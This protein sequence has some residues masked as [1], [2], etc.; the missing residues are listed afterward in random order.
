MNKTL[1]QKTQK[2]EIHP[3]LKTEGSMLPK[4]RSLSNPL[5]LEYVRFS[6]FHDTLGGVLN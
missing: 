4:I 3:F 6:P 2:A 1:T 5:E